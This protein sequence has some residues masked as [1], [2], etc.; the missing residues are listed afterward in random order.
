MLRSPAGVHAS[1]AAAAR[2]TLGCW[3]G[4]DVQ[5]DELSRGGSLI[6]G[7]RVIGD[8]RLVEEDGALDLPPMR[9]NHERARL[10]V[11]ALCRGVVSSHEL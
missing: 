9:H 5:L 8:K 6:N 2:L 1:S 10:A 11:E 4:G 3:R 7:R